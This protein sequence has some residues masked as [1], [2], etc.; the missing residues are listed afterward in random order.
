MAINTVAGKPAAAVRDDPAAVLPVR[1][2]A[3]AGARDRIRANQK[4]MGAMPIIRP[5]SARMAF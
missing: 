5:P 2:P 3:R 1:H 4:K